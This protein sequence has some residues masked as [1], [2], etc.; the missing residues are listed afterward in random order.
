MRTLTGEYS[1][2]RLGKKA[3]RDKWHIGVYP[4]RLT[5]LYRYLVQ[6]GFYNT[7]GNLIGVCTITF[8]TRKVALRYANWKA[9]WMELVH[10]DQA[11]HA[12]RRGYRGG[13]TGA[14]PRRSMPDNRKD[15][16][17]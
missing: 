5:S 17:Q 1:G 14:P 12:T 8:K 3:L 11:R 7:A 9:E 10:Q 2:M 16:H 13:K 4:T 15:A 6:Q